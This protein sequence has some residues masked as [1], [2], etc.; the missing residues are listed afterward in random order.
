[1]FEGSGYKTCFQ[2]P[3]TARLSELVT[4][5]ACPDRYCCH[6]VQSNYYQVLLPILLFQ[7]PN[8]L[9]MPLTTELQSASVRRLLP[10]PGPPREIVP[11]RC[12][13]Q[14]SLLLFQGAA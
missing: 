9:Q 6:S 10:P 1:M 4:Q 14:E 2:L 11:V 3:L 8:T 7:C 12:S 13:P 5:P